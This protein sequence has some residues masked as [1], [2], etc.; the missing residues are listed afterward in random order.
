MSLPQP[1][2]P[3]LSPHQSSTI[4][5]WR[6]PLNWCSCYPTPAFF[7]TIP[8]C[9][10]TRNFCPSLPFKLLLRLLLEGHMQ[11]WE[12]KYLFLLLLHFSFLLE[13]SFQARL[14]LLFILMYKVRSLFLTMLY[15]HITLVYIGLH[16]IKQLLGLPPP[17]SVFI[18]FY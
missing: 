14:F 5:Y 17:L 10:T 6:S 16:I 12:S 13:S 18:R 1:T 8:V 3:P 11:K 15:Q 7:C 2:V 9:R 4:I